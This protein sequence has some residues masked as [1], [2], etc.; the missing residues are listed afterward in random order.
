MA[1][2]PVKGDE[3]KEPKG[4]ADGKVWWRAGRE[5]AKAGLGV[6]AQWRGQRK[7]AW[8][9]QTYGDSRKRRKMEPPG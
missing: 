2:S 6:A 9:L 1:M 5:D 3:R 8:Q 4:A 7:T